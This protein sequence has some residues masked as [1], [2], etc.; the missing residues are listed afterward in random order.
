M[1]SVECKF[2]FLCFRTDRNV[3]PN[4]SLDPAP[5]KELHDLYDDCIDS[6]PM[7]DEQEV[8]MKPS[9]HK[10]SLSLSSS[11]SVSAALPPAADSGNVSDDDSEDDTDSVLSDKRMWLI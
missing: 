9:P 1:Q 10:W 2:A 11:S 3:A 6:E 7:E 8:L 5:Y 4:V